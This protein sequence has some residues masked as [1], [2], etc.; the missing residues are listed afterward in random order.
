MK[1]PTEILKEEHRAVLEKLAALEGVINDL[2]H[3]E[4]VSAKL[5]ELASFFETD[6]W[7]HFDKEEKA[8]FPEFDGFMPRGSGPLA[9]M[10]DEHGVIRNTNEVMQE[11]VSSYL[12]GDRSAET[13]KTIRQSGMHFIQFL[14]AHISKEDSLLPRMAEMH[15]GQM[16]NERVVKLF[17][18]IEK[19]SEN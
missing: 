7:V 18:E 3:E 19:A 6:F 10:V 5:K 11:S 16:Q 4:K 13:R 14:R 12:N 8:L 2:E 1:N 17:S 15:L 9:A